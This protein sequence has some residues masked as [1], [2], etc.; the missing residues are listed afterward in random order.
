MSPRNV[1]E[2]FA[3]AVGFTMRTKIAFWRIQL[4]ASREAAITAW[5]TAD[6]DLQ[7]DTG[8]F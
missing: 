7:T 6:A 5:A 1:D 8:N 4:L 2:H 3:P